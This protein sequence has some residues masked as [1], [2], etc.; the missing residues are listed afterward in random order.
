MGRLRFELRTNR[1][2]AECSTAELATR[3]KVPLRSTWGTYHMGIG[4]FEG[5]VVS[6]RTGHHD[7][8]DGAARKKRV[9]HLGFEPR[10]DRLRA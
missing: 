1:L 2:K 6:P 9:G 10:T 5:A 7:A 3:N 4:A 8:S